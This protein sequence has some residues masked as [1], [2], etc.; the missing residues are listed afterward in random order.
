[1]S[2]KERFTGSDEKVVTTADR[3]IMQ[4]V[5]GIIRS[6]KTH[7]MSHYNSSILGKTLMRRSL[8]RFQIQKNINPCEQTCGSIS[9]NLAAFRGNIDLFGPFCNIIGH[10]G[11]SPA[12]VKD[13]VMD[14][15]M[16]EVV[17]GTLGNLKGADLF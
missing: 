14:N 10:Q 3:P 2:L 12:L 5:A 8:Y 11:L 4:H 15:R 1:M 7:P 6:F 17:P 16:G 9:S 13:T